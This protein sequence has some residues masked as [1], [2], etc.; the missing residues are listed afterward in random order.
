MGSNG[1]DFRISAFV[2]AIGSVFTGARL[3]SAAVFTVGPGGTHSTV[4]SAIDAAVATPEADEIRLRNRVFRENLVLVSV[5]QNLRISG[6][7]NAGFTR[8]AP[9]A[10]STLDGGGTGRVF[11]GEVHGGSLILERLQV[12]GG[13]T[14]DSGAGIMVDLK[15]RRDLRDPRQHRG[16]QLCS[17]RRRLA[18]RGGAYVWLREGARFAARRVTFSRN[19][20]K[21][22][23]SGGGAGLSVGGGEVSSSVAIANCRFL[24]NDITVGPVPSAAYGAG[25]YVTSATTHIEIV[26]NLIQRNRLWSE[27]FG[28]GIG[29]SVLSSGTSQVEARRNRI[30][31]QA[32]PAG[33]NASQV[34]FYARG[35]AQVRFSD[36]EIARSTLHGVL[37]WN[38]AGSRPVLRL[39]N[40]TVVDNG[41]YGVA[42]DAHAPGVTTLANSIVFGS[43]FSNIQQLRNARLVRNLIGI[44]PL[45][46]DRAAA[47]YRL[48]SGSRALNRGMASPPGGLGPFD[49]AGRPRVR[50]SAVDQGANEIQ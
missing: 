42:V 16:R 14:A 24:D 36:S 39:V 49:V 7:W 46:V 9:A 48:R 3:A 33:S 19:A 25:V 29:L 37:A 28:Y 20:L 45:F 1:C 13:Q 12:K 22:G 17:G 40:L 8:A 34:S 38:E 41:V 32:A 5:D 4:Q 10:R 50:G 18:G 27:T 15:P 30:L 2:L 35:E 21:T 26:D 11:Q 43:G 44:D 23:G 6:G 31:D 47:D